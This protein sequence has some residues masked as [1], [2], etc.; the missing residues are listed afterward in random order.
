MAVILVMMVIYDDDIGDNG[1]IGE[2]GDV[3]DD[4]DVGDVG[5]DGDVGVEGVLVMVILVM[6]M[7][8]CQIHVL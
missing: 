6:T 4:G 2:D 8:K 5:D 7:T 1:D 3:V